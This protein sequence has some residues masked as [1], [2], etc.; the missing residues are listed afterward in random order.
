MW[1]VVAVNDGA[2]IVPFLCDDGVGGACSDCCV[3]AGSVLGSLVGFDD[4][5]VVP[6]SLDGGRGL[7]PSG[8]VGVWSGPEGLGQVGRWV[9]DCSSNA[10]FEGPVD[11]V[12]PVQ[13]TG[14]GVD[15]VVEVGER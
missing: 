13:R 10:R 1:C 5:G 9:V 15:V 3:L 14:A 2:D 11:G 6:V 7:V 4:A 12:D 8:G